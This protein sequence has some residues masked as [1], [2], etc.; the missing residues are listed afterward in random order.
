MILNSNMHILIV[1]CYV[2]CTYLIFSVQENIDIDFDHFLKATIVKDLE[3]RITA[4]D[5]L[6]HPFLANEYTPLALP[7]ATYSRSLCI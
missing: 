1:Y 4:N 7:F 3:N 2:Y 5:C 6:S